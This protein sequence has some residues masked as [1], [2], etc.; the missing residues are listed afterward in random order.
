MLTGF[1]GMDSLF[2]HYHLPGEGNLR[3]FV[4]RG[5]RG[6]ESL[7][8]STSEVSIYKNLARPDKPELFLNFLHFLMVVSFGIEKN[9]EHSI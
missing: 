3:G 2:T 1:Y 6:A 5:E 9:I 8:A 4:G 7:I